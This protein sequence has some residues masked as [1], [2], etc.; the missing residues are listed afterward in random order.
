MGRTAPGTLGTSD[1]RLLGLESE[2]GGLGMRSATGAVG[3]TRR[4][5]PSFWTT[6]AVAISIA[7]LGPLTTAATSAGASP[8]AAQ[9]LEA[10]LAAVSCS[11][12]TACTAVGSFV[13]KAGTA[14][15][16]LA[17]RWNGTSWAI[18]S[19]PDRADAAVTVLSGVSCASVNACFAVGYYE[20]HAE[21]A[22]LPFGEAW[23]GTT[24]NIQAIPAR[25]TADG[26]ALTAVS[27][28]SPTSCTAVGYYGNSTTAD[29]SLAAVWNGTRWTSEVPAHGLGGSALDAVACTSATSCTATGS[30]DNGGFFFAEAS[31]G[32]TWTITL[33]KLT[34]IG[35]LTG[36]S[37]ATASSCVAVGDDRAGKPLAEVWN[38]SA[39]TLESVTSSGIASGVSCPSTSACIAVGLLQRGAA[40]S[41]AWVSSWNGSSWSD[42]TAAPADKAVADTLSGVSCTSPAACVA[43]GYSTYDQERTSD[44]TMSESWNGTVW[45][46]ESTPD[47]T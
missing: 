22:P 24:W 23:N 4:L 33:K 29:D 44:A 28:F 25:A 46:M 11:S 12:S 35:S 40:E 42:Q 19:V 21:G 27:C 9:P 34:T 36:V 26:S 3:P 39:W 17:E 15:K 5:R 43:V 41:P 14:T 47:P 13:S 1:D 38:G 18:Q 2:H 45:T 37:C 30:Q 8:R 20:M 7:V 32:N 10:T 16:A 31:N 6:A